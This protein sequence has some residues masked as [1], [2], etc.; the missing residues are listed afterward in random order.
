MGGPHQGFSNLGCKLNGLG[1]GDNQINKIIEQ[2][3]IKPPHH[4]TCPPGSQ[5][6]ALQG[7]LESLRGEMEG[8]QQE[9]EE[10]RAGDVG[11]LREQVEMLK[12]LYDDE[13]GFSVKVGW[14]VQTAKQGQ[15]GWAGLQRGRVLSFV[16]GNVLDP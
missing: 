8:L 15:C 3:Y 12:E 2:Q 13:R 9:L 4:A 14:E 16:G 10:L 11:S 1:Q 6:S 5:V 7:E